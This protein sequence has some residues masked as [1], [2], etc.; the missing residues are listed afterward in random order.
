MFGPPDTDSPHSAQSTAWGI[1]RFSN[2]ELRQRFVDMCVDQARILGLDL[3]D[4]DLTWN[5][6]RQ[7]YDFGPIDWSELN[8][9]IRGDGPCNADRMERR[10]GAHEDGA[11]VREAASVYAAKQSAKQ[12]G[13]AV[14]A[15]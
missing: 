10:V 2:D 5:Q 7:H 11:W 15:A 13:A 4:P 3:P 9:V 14:V 8:R 1:K 12:S 6:D